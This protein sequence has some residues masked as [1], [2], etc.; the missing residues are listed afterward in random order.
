MYDYFAD[1]LAW[2]MPPAMTTPIPEGYV[3]HLPNRNP[4]PRHLFGA[5]LV[6]PPQRSISGYEQHEKT[7]AICHAVRVTVIPDNG[8]TPWREWREK[9]AL[10][11]SRW[12]A[13]CRMVGET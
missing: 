12:P 2:W 3:M 7:C 5:A 8:E 10:T 6:V 1:Y 9:D 11:Q 4:Q 13:A